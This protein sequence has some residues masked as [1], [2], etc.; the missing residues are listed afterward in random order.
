[1]RLPRSALTALSLGILWCEP[2][3]AQTPATRAISERQV[4]EAEHGRRDDDAKVLVEALKGSDTRVQR[5]A[6]RALGRFERPS[7][8]APLMMMLTASDS[9][10]RAE[11]VNA[12]AQIGAAHPYHELLEK[13]RNGFVRGVIYETIG[14]VR[15]TPEGAEATLARGLADASLIARAGAAR[16]LES[17]LRRTARNTRP[18][19]AT[20]I[21]LRRTA[22]DPARGDI[23]AEMRENALLALSAASDRDSATVAAALRDPSEQVR[24]VAVSLARHFV[25]D[26]SYIVRL[27]ALRYAG[28]CE[29]FIAAT[30]DANEHVVLAALDSLGGR[31]CDLGVLVRHADAGRTWR[32]KAHAA[33]ALAK[34]A[35]DSARVRVR[36]LASSPVWQARV[37]AATAARVLHDSATL[38]TLASDAEPNVVAVSMTS[39]DDALRALRSD[40]SGLIMAAVDWLAGEL[41]SKQP[42]SAASGDALLATLDRLTQRGVVTTRDPRMRLI[43]ALGVRGDSAHVL[44]AMRRLLG[45]K[46]PQVASAAAAVATTLSGTPHKATTTRY[47]PAPLPSESFMRELRGATARLQVRGVGVV[48]LTLLS[49]DAPVA[50]ATFVDLAERGKF[51][52]LTFHRIV[53]N[54]V[55]QGGS[56]G[57]DEFDALTTWFMR[58]EVGLAR[59]ARGTFGISTRGRDTGD[60]QIYINLIDNFRLDHDYT[61]FARTLRGLDVIDRIQEGDV[62]ESI[63]IIRPSRNR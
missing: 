42:M 16:G 56:P 43:S 17:L 26:P 60:G 55:V 35:P 5:L 52:G 6:A 40:H 28:T 19:D 29:R 13:E 44:A 7:L 53:P 20:L 24:R 8:A 23:A 11:A 54:F 38:R 18:A 41:P 4:L 15:P 32:M 34:I 59:N 58:D 50:A 45:D 9:L 25:D 36:T 10:V 30:R 47:E 49:D 27:Q 12:M 21:A 37:Y 61:V 14:R 2:I 1:M 51:N 46:D 39:D 57:A 33:V 31:A 48:E 62:I 63:R 3:R 22:V